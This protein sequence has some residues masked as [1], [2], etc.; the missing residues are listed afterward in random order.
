MGGIRT[1]F[2]EAEIAARVETLAGEIAR[3]IPGDFVMVGL[4]KG[5]AVFLADLA[6]ALD[7]AGPTPR[8]S[9]CG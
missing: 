4:L 5:A 3:T 9:L 7:R 1:L 8:L 6:R 2:S